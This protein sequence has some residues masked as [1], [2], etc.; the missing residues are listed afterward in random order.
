MAY[1]RSDKD[2]KELNKGEK[3]DFVPLINSL[4][5]VSHSL[6]LRLVSEYRNDIE[7]R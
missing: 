3:E 1:E 6:K 7:N 2:I 5:I 4:L